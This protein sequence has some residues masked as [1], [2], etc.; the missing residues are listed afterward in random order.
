VNGIIPETLDEFESVLC[1][2]M[3]DARENICVHNGDGCS[4]SNDNVVKGTTRCLFKMLGALDDS[5]LIKTVREINRLTE[6]NSS[7]KNKQA[8]ENQQH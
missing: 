6:L 8:H 3:K 2:A 5:D 4:V 7:G 1:E